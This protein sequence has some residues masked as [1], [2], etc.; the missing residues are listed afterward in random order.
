VDLRSLTEEFHR[1]F[2]ETMAAREAA[3]VASR[4]AIRSS[5]N[6]I[7]AIHR[8]EADEAERLMDEAERWLNGQ[9]WELSTAERLLV[10]PE[11]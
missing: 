10:D 1:R 5:A 7:R 4:K 6:A 3:L 9:A 2:D 8:A 11:D